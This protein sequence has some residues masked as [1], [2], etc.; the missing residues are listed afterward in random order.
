MN[1]GGGIME[2]HILCIEDDPTIQMLVAVALKEYQV[3][4]AYSI[5]EAEAAINKFHFNA[6]LIDVQLP[7]G[8]GLRFLA[9][10]YQDESYHRTPV[11]VFSDHSEISNKVMAFALGA[12][13]FISKPFDLLE[14]KARVA[15]KIR[16]QE[17]N[18]EKSNRRKLGNIIID[19]DRQKAFSVNQ[20]LE[21]DLG[22]TSIELKILGLLT[23][24][25]EHV[26]SREQIMDQI[27]GKT[28]ISDRTIDSHIAHLRNKIDNSTLL[29]ETAK[30]FGYR[31]VLRA[32]PEIT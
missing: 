21:Q 20:N 13:D 31:A 6:L 12:E 22:L 29:I 1:E 27:W 2:S 10:L 3:I 17:L 11:L 9:K 24:R 19:F 26:F 16:K 4:P 23:K 5:S 8:D 15:A 7:D 32:R 30:T 25:L 18:F 28:Y 14:L